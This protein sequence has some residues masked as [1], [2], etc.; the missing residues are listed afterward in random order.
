MIYW[1]SESLKEKNIMREEGLNILRK[2]ADSVDM[3]HPYS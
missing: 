3:R 1:N 2:V